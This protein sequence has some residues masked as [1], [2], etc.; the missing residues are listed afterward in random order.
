MKP[1]HTFIYLCKI[2]PKQIAFIST[3]PTYK[4]KYNSQKNINFLILDEP[5]NHLDI[6]G[7][8]ELEDILASY[9]ETLLVVSHDRYFLQKVATTRMTIAD[10]RITK[11]E[12]ILK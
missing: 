5:T 8:E 3:Q 9:Q 1:I 4:K 7:K 11:K 12:G 10:Q 6:Y 2:S